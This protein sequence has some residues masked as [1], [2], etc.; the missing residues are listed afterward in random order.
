MSQSAVQTTNTAATA[1]KVRE[2][3]AYID[4]MPGT[5]RRLSVGCEVEV[6]ATNYV[7]KLLPFHSDKPEILNFLLIV[8]EVPE[9]GLDVVVWI[10]ARYDREH[11][12]KNPNFARIYYAGEMVGEVPVERIS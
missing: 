6:P 11:Y 5:P 4:E 12:K 2:I 8:N 3:Y 10:P 7:A 1:I 9:L